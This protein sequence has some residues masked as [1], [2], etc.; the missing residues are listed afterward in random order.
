MIH[1]PASGRRG[2]LRTAAA[3]AA[4]PP[5]KARAQL[6]GTATLLV[7][8]PEDGAVARWAM[9]LSAV[10]ARGT[11]AAV[12]LDHSILGGADGVTA[13]NRFATAAGPDGRTLLVLPGAAIAA[14]LAGD[15][16]ARFDAAGWLAVCASQ[17]SS[18]V[19][20]R[21]PPAPGTTL[22][23]GFGGADSPGAAAL[24]GLDLLGVAAVPVPGLSPMQSEVALAQD[25][26]DAALLQ[27]ADLPAR[28]AALGA[29][30]WFTL[31][32]PGTRDPA[33]PDLPALADLPLA[34]TPPIL[35]GF[36]AAAAA[37]RLRAALVL[38]A[39]TPANL[40][41]L[42]RNAAGRWP[43]EERAA[44]RA[45]LRALPGTEAAALVAAL[46]PPPEAVLAWREWLLR[47][48]NWRAGDH[49][50]LRSNMNAAP[51]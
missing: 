39:L 6:P 17:A 29:R 7:P 3:L 46:A 37:A 2:L 35:A 34:G 51:P 16:R 15:P 14:R 47:R 32:A 42:W 10:L 28:I 26:V 12:R 21:R 8:G 40:V 41:A 1:R 45:G 38:P 48:L 36:Q 44:T 11:T 23:F 13:A 50:G 27:G 19:A 43:E 20:V 4:V 31:E 5:G 25:A 33:L 49:S 24:L 30:P 9:R 22:R 18:V